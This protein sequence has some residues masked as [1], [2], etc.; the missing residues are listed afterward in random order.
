MTR[1]R[2]TGKYRAERR[3]MTEQDDREIKVEEVVRRQR[4]EGRVGQH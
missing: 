3:Y 1:G 4:T 2:Y